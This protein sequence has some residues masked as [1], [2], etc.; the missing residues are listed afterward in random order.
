MKIIPD[1]H[2]L[3][4]GDVKKSASADKTAD[5]DRT[6]GPGTFSDLL[7]RISTT[8]SKTMTQN[9]GQITGPAFQNPVP[10]SEQADALAAGEQA[11]ALMQHLSTILMG[12][13]NSMD[14][15][16]P[17]AKALDSSTRDLLEMRDALDPHDPLRNTIDEIGVMSVVASMKIE[18]G[19]FNLP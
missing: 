12:A 11:L 13:D 4:L 7:N 15:F 1:F 16:D 2:T 6:D 3:G 17:V 18:R 14:D 8:Q 5:T 10:A 19:D 9:A